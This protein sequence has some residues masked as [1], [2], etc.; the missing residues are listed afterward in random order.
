MVS[1]RKVDALLFGG[2]FLI[3]IE[4]GFSALTKYFNDLEL[5]QSG[6]S[7]KDL[8][9]K[10]DISMAISIISPNGK[11]DPVNKS[12]FE[13]GS[14]SKISLSGVMQMDG[15]M[16]S[17]GIAQLAEM[18]QN[19]DAHPNIAGH[20]FDVN[21]GGGEAVAGIHLYNTVKDLKK[22]SVAQVHTCAS[23]GYLAM[24]PVN[25]I[26]ALSTMSRIGSIGA[27]ISMDKKFIDW[28]KENIDDIY[29]NLSPEKNDALNSYL[30]GDKTKLVNSLDSLVQDFHEKVMKHRRLN[31][32]NKKETLK[33][34]TFYSKEAKSRGL[35]DSIG[36]EAYATKRLNFYI[37][38]K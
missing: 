6:I 27:M 11:T 15:G 7:L 13:P 26:V 30:N 8:G 24:L 9:Y 16:S 10:N 25:E 31:P 4:F 34:N 12:S 29:S 19:L 5:V 38:N 20:K 36:T 21:T 17:V 37:N 2:K 18:I 32:E 3:D 28:Y 14:H 33:G 22:P 35:I 23:A 1:N